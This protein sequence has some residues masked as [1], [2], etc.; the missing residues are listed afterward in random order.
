[1]EVMLGYSF[2]LICNIMMH[3]DSELG[4]QEDVILWFGT[5]RYIIN[6]VR[7]LG[8]LLHMKIVII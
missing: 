7:G 3:P 5:L 4:L 6:M 8:L 2:D 1:M